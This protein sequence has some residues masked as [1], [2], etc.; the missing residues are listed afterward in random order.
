MRPADR[1][2]HG[3]DFHWIDAVSATPAAPYEFAWGQR[4]ALFGSGR[5]AMRVLIEWGAREHSWRR[6]WLPSYYCQDVPAALRELSA[7]G[8]QLRAYA[9]G[10]D[11][12]E[13]ANSG[14]RTEP[15]DV[16]VIHNH[17]GLR[18]SP[19]S[20]EA[21]APDAVIV[22]DHSHDLAA[23]WAMNSRAHYAVASLR[24]TLPLP[25]GG[26]AWSPRV[27]ALPPEPPPSEVHAA[28]AL[29]R[30]SAMVLKG[31]YLAGHAVDKAAFR[32]LAMSG[33]ERMAD[34][35]PSGISPVSRAMLPSLPVVAW[36]EQRRENYDTLLRALGPLRNVH[37]LAP[38]PEAVPFALTLVFDT[39]K[40]R[41]VVKRALIAARVYPAVLWS[42]DHP[43]LDDIPK[44]HVDLAR[45][46]LSIHCDQRYASGDMIRV[47]EISKPLVGV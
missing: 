21:F 8:V 30:L 14:L 32:T 28:A 25:D 33:E 18:R 34:G 2:E 47:A 37:V 44:E 27:L 19:A 16:V 7:E 6:V 10:P 41:D 45:R 9:D 1:I 5:D 43:M 26:V 31:R 29:D 38:V 46:V 24:K 36:R 17:F 20:L 3:S 42:L 35:P 15:G 12:E 4:A 11:H 22:E 23:P 13:P 40:A 39:P